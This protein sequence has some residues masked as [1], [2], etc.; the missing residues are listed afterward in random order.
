LQ[1]AEGPLFLVNE[2]LWKWMGNQGDPGLTPEKNS[3]AGGSERVDFK[4]FKQKEAPL[5]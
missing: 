2:P 1:P 4:G 3:S 5:S